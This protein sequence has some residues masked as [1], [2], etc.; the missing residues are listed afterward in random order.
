MTSKVSAGL[1]NV[2]TKKSDVVNLIAQIQ[3]S[4][5][6][7]ITSDMLVRDIGLVS[8]GSAPAYLP[9]ASGYVALTIPTGEQEL[10]SF[11]TDAM[12]KMGLILGGCVVISVVVGYLWNKNVWW[13][14]ALLF[15]STDYAELIGCCDRVLVLYDGAV[16]RTLVEGAI[17]ER[18][19]V[20]SALN[21]DAPGRTAGIAMG[22][23]P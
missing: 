4:K 10:S 3:I 2:Y 6:S 20:A 21:I 18:A 7:I 12:I 14:A 16:K 22:A 1:V 19:L 17:T 23:E 11:S 15:Y 5:G 13:K 9:L 8:A